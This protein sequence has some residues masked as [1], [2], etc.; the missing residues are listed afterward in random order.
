MKHTAPTN[1][2]FYALP[3]GTVEDLPLP[4]NI[5]NLFGILKCHVVGAKARSETISSGRVETLNEDVLFHNYLQVDVPDA[6]VMVNDASV[7]I[8]DIIASNDITHV[9]DSVLIPPTDEP[10]NW[11]LFEILELADSIYDVIANR[12]DF[13]T[14]GELNI[15]FLMCMK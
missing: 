6:G 3:D 8:P 1:R 15:L 11:T 9:I 7:V 4:K 10:W 13:S 2:A 5:D 14:L 12:E